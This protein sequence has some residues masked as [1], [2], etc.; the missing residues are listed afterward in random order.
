MRF[1]QPVGTQAERNASRVWA[2]QW[3][4][5]TGFGANTVAGYNGYH[6]GADLNLP[7]LADVKASV[8]ASASG[9]VVFAGVASGFQGQTIVIA[10]GNVDNQA[11]WTRYSHLADVRVTKN[12]LVARGTQIGVIGDYL[13]TGAANDHLHFDVARID[14]GAKPADWPGQDLQ[15]LLRDYI[16]PR[17]WINAHRDDV[18]DDNAKRW[19]PTDHALGT[20]VRISPDTA[21]SSNIVGVIAGRDVVDGELSADK[22]WVILKITPV[23]MRIGQTKLTPSVNPTFTG[24]AAREFMK[25][26]QAVTPPPQ[27]AVDTRKLLGVHE[28]A[29]AGRA[30]DALVMGA[31]CVMVFE[32]ALGAM[33]MADAYRDAI[34][35]HR[36]YFT[37]PLSP[38]DLLAQHGID[39]NG[40]S[41][42]RAWYRGYNENDV[43]GG[44]DS[45]PSGIRKR[46][47]FDL[48]CAALLRR[49]APNA[50]W[51]AGGWA[52][53]NPDI[54]N[55]D[56]CA[57]LRDGYSAAYNRGEIAFDLHNYSKS[58]PNNPKDY[59]YYAPEWFERRWE[60]LFTKCGFDPRVRRIVSSEGGIEAGAGGFRWAG[61]TQ[62]EFDEWMRYMLNVLSQ[63]IVV[64]GVTN[65]SP[66]VG[67]TIFQW[68]NNHNGAG[69]W[70]GYG[71]DEYVSRLKAAYDGLIPATKEI[72]LIDVRSGARP[73]T[74]DARQKIM[75]MG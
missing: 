57:A 36:K 56:V 15:R 46:A 16:D 61:F 9:V 38:R 73:D 11:I 25:P 20:R 67:M 70:W 69:G 17:E 32:D 62:S 55:A 50:V 37:V 28:L 42:S 58:N 51:V 26:A 2:G 27:T 47:E 40:T 64:G 49:A 53:G 72:A 66:F 14:L 52:H 5:A 24:Y 68:G 75:E 1:D 22:K 30:R 48:E 34:V 74:G 44:Y 65:A 23:E 59:R 8:Y 71:L 60:H 21:T 10:H 3:F 35:M 39:P 31:R 54:T 45:S 18:T 63:P 7:A 19:T 41:Q 29:N 12:D 13:P 43:G 4:D 33:Q 6:T